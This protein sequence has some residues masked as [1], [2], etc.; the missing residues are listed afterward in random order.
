MRDVGAYMLSLNAGCGLSI[1]MTGE[2][3]RSSA[4]V[5]IVPKNGR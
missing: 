2:P 4:A 5:A 1:E 3:G